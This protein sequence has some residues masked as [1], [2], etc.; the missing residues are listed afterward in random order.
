M[1]H[2]LKTHANI[3]SFVSLGFSVWRH[4]IS[5]SVLRRCTLISSP[6]MHD[7]S[8]NEA[9]APATPAG[10]GQ[11]GA[12]LDKGQGCRYEEALRVCHLQTPPNLA[13]P[14]STARPAVRPQARRAYASPTQQTE[15]LRRGEHPWEIGMCHFIRPFRRRKVIRV[16]RWW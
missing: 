8:Q 1:S 10:C 2:F 4:W 13:A 16:R 6:H 14:S 9:G 15:S 11:A 12:H 3:W 5:I 7:S